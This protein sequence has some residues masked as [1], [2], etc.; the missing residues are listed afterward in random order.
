MIT[1]NNYEEFFLLYVDG[2]LSAAE[3]LAVEAFVEGHPDLKEEFDMMLQCRLEPEGEEV[4]LNR[5]VLLQPSEE[6]L[7]LYVDGELDAAGRALVEGTLDPVRREE[8][9][10]LQ[11]TVVASDVSVVFPDKERLYRRRRVVLMPWMSV[12]AAAVTIGAVLMLVFRGGDDETQAGSGVRPGSQKN[13]YAAVTPGKHDTLHHSTG[14]EAVTEQ[15]GVVGT[16]VKVKSRVED[17]TGGEQTVIPARSK[18]VEQSTSLASTDPRSET[19]NAV[20]NT[21]AEKI[22]VMGVAANSST[23][24]VAAGSATTATGSGSTGSGMTAAAGMTTATNTAATTTNNI[25]ITNNTATTDNT[26]ARDH[27]GKTASFAT[28]ALLAE[29]GATPDDEEDPVSPKKNKLRGFFR[30]VSRVIEKRTTKDDDE[31]HKVYLGGFAIK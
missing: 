23:G 28:Q 8:L 19:S 20:G 26:I 9:A 5:D 29:A 22:A 6:T 16:A 31:N 1:R 18:R 14:V 11:R 24:T 27:S 25:A 13:T 12:A 2:E 3:K 15:K 7:L 21:V 17:K 4:F 30:K 10:W